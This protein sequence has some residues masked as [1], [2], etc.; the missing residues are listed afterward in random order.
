MAQNLAQAV[1]LIFYVVPNWLLC[2]GPIF[3]WIVVETFFLLS[4]VNA[5]TTSQHHTTFALQV[6]VPGSLATLV[7]TRATGA[8]GEERYESRLVILHVRLR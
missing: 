4:W 6:F 5:L 8:V 1:A 7:S 3:D 2:Q